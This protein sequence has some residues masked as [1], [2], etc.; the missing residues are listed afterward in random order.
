MVKLILMFFSIVYSLMLQAG[1]FD[2]VRGPHPY[3]FPARNAQSSLVLYENK[4]KQESAKSQLSSILGGSG[5]GIF[6]N[7]TTISAGN[8]QQIE[9]TLSEGSEGM[10]MSES[11]QDS[12]GNAQ[13]NSQIN[14]DSESTKNSQSAVGDKDSSHSHNKT[15]DKEKNKGNGGKHY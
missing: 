8:W 7:N 3:S 2:P 14:N 1:Q 4:K 12:N 15:K 9:M 10:I 5:T 11:H 6:I 13:S